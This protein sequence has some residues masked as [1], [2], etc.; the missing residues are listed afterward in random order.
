VV[1]A[2]IAFAWIF[3]WFCEKPFLAR[4]ARSSLPLSVPPHEHISGEIVTS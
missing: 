1:P 2:T 3:F 4:R